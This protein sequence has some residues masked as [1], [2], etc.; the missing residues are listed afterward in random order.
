MEG[1]GQQIAASA[2]GG[3]TFEGDRPRVEQPVEAH[4][5]LLFGTPF[6]RS[7]KVN[8]RMYRVEGVRIL[9][10]SWVGGRGAP[11]RSGRPG[12]AQAAT[13]RRDSTFSHNPPT[14]S[15]T[16]RTPRPSPPTLVVVIIYQPQHR[17]EGAE[18]SGAGVGIE[19]MQ[20]PI[21]PACSG[22][23][24]GWVRALASQAAI[25]AR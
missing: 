2:A 15:F 24:A 10:D 1:G 20:Y 25:S 16:T 13:A 3:V 11:G 5:R 14:L 23:T 18:Q 7:F 9:C 4:D 8:S 6:A 22:C 21:E 19:S 17:R 12:L